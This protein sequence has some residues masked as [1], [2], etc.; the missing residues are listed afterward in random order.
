MSDALIEEGPDK[1]A[2]IPQYM[3]VTCSMVEGERVWASEPLVGWVSQAT[4][5]N[6]EDAVATLR[7]IVQNGSATPHEIGLLAYLQYSTGLPKKA[8]ATLEQ[9]EVEHRDSAAYA[10]ADVILLFTERVSDER[11]KQAIKS[12][13]SE[14]KDDKFWFPHLISAIY[15][16]GRSDLVLATLPHAEHQYHRSPANPRIK[17]KLVKLYLQSNRK[18]EASDLI[19]ELISRDPHNVDALI[20]RVFTLANNRDRIELL[21]EIIAKWPDEG[22]AYRFRGDYSLENGDKEMAKKD[23]Q[24]ATR[25]GVGRSQSHSHHNLAMLCLEESV[26]PEGKITDKV[27]AKEGLNHARAACESTPY[28]VKGKSIMYAT[29]FALALAVHGEVQRSIAVLDEADSQES[30][31]QQEQQ[32]VV[33]TRRKVNYLRIKEAIEKYK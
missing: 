15:A 22:E 2:V 4:L 24:Q 11:L 17:E 7:L 16:Y 31:N 6:R 28:S 20:L 32:L 29:S 30:L 23:Y 33:D 1:G 5:R 19:E 10:F 13:M 9:F 26:T 21:T 25:I 14:H 27:L 3:T 12:L 18:A 8:R